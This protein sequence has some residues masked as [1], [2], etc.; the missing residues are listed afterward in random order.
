[1]IPLLL[2]THN[3]HKTAEVRAIL[4]PGIE[5]TDLTT[6]PGALE[7]EETGSTFAE[8]AGIKALA[9]SALAGPEVWVLADDS[10]L[11]VDAL[12]GRSGSAFSPVF[13]PSGR[14]CGAPRQ[15]A[16]RAGAGRG[17]RPV[18]TGA[19]RF[20]CVLALARAGRWWRNSKGRWKDGSPTRGA[21][22]GWLWIRP[23][24][25]PRRRNEHL[26]RAARGREKHVQPP[27]ARPGRLAASGILARAE[28][29]T[30]S[31]EAPGLSEAGANLVVS[32]RPSVRLADDCF[33]WLMR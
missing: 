6:W 4:G 22:H 23:A 8:N 13:R 32:R 11:E 28:T 19:A 26:R 16:G 3:A 15:I 30:R 33:T 25:H 24:V 29:K 14:Q 20:R 27:G 12:G 5:V 10:G 17:R 18:R 1:M 31:W 2:A 21:W 9:A 7:P